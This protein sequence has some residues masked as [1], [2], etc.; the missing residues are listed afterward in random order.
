M[1]V[2]PVDVGARRM[3]WTRLIAQKSEGTPA[4]TTSEQFEKNLEKLA[5]Y[6]KKLSTVHSIRKPKAIPARNMTI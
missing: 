4:S 6:E 3:S 1:D 2:S 5:C